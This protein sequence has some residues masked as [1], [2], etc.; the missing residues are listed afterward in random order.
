MIIPER[1]D[2]KSLIILNTLPYPCADKRHTGIIAHVMI[3]I[4]HLYPNREA[5]VK[6]PQIL[7]R[8]QCDIIILSVETISS[9]G[10]TKPIARKACPIYTAMMPV[11]AVV[12]IS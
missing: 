9:V 1:T 11:K 7:V 4:V 8:S 12:R 6:L 3:I 10:V 2:D 5:H